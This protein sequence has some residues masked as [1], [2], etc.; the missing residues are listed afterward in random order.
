MRNST[1]FSLFDKGGLSAAGLKL[2]ACVFMFI[3]HMG[4]LLFPNALFL[5]VIGRLAFP[6]FA[7]FIAEGCRYSR[8]GLRRFLTIFLLGAVCETVYVL[9][10]GG[11]YGNIL[12]TFSCSILLITLLQ[13]WKR[14]MC[15]SDR[16]RQFLYFLVFFAASALIGIVIS[17]VGIDYG[18]PGV[19]LP[20]LISLFDYREGAAPEPLK[21]LDRPAVKLCITAAGLLLVAAQPNL[22]ALQYFSL[23]AL[24]L[25][26]LYN[27]K[28]G[29]KGFKYG[30]YVFYPAHLLLLQTV[31][32]LIH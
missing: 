29:P 15:G 16:K 23:F 6:I 22:H 25:L 20:V 30:F 4:L 31:A 19:M 5:R 7:F 26:A 17:R 18:F 10:S 2:L 14:S 28:P 21:K 12:L 9:F 32:L 27:G 8:H 1:N 11:W 13:A 24:P 3:D